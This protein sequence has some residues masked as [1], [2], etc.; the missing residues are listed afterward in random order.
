MPRTTKTS[1]TSGTSRRLEA[2]PD[3]T[4]TP[5][6]CRRTDAEDRLW[7]ALYDQPGSSAAQLALA[8]GIGKSTAGKIL[9]AWAKDATVTRTP[10]EAQGRRRVADRWTITETDDQPTPAAE[11]TGESTHT[12]STP[13][14]NP[15]EPGPECQDVE[16]D[17]GSN[18]D[19]DTRMTGEQPTEPAGAPTAAATTATDEAITPSAPEVPVKAPRLGKGALRGMVEDF[20]TEHPGEQFSPNKIGKELGRSAGAVFN[21]LEKLVTSGWA[22]R[23]SD[24]PKR[25][26]AKSSTNTSAAADTATD[27]AAPGAQREATQPA[28]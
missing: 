13:G 2:V 12:D 14:E 6:A 18:G 10:G 17:A 5:D 24:A 9:A 8:A 20:L 4:G 21:A 22:V 19:S 26:T 27:A 1:R 16:D 28:G 23:T 25:Y 3:A 15:V 7:A 11:D